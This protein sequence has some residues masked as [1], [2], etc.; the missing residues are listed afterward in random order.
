MTT[1]QLVSYT[2]CSNHTV[3]TV[4]MKKLNMYG[5]TITQES[6]EILVIMKCFT[7]GCT[8]QITFKNGNSRTHLIWCLSCSL[9]S[10]ACFTT[11]VK[12]DLDLGV[13]RSV[14]SGEFDQ[15]IRCSSSLSHHAA[16]I[17][18]S[19]GRAEEQKFDLH[20]TSGQCSTWFQRVTDFFYLQLETLTENQ[21]AL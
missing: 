7:F 20:F 3:W 18:V 16:V 6:E 17:R 5:D 2:D 1:D 12:I 4:W 21:L 13:K 9:Q 11:I 8:M 14:F 15:V 19:L 10:S